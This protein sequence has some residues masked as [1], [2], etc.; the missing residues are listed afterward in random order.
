MQWLPSCVTIAGHRQWGKLGRWTTTDLRQYYQWTTMVWRQY[1]IVYKALSG[2]HLRGLISILKYVI[3]TIT[4]Q[5]F[6]GPQFIHTPGVSEAA[7][8]VAV[9]GAN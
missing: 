4:L 9:L 7:L 6:Q 2:Q 5:K 3:K 1:Q 8:H